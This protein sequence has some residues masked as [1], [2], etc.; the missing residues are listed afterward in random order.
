M[1][2]FTTIDLDEEIKEEQL[3]IKQEGK[4]NKFVDKVQQI[5][6]SAK[7]ARLSNQEILYIT[8]RA[9][10]RLIDEGIE[11]I[12]IA[13]GVDLEKDIL[14]HMDFTPVISPNLK[15]MDKRIFKNIPMNISI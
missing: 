5:T 11:L 1:G 14:N 2:T 9:V 13:P 8:E 4:K 12:E 15:Q 3:I 6:F 7:Q 10:F